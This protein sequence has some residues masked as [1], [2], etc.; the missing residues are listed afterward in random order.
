NMR[1]F[2]YG[3]VALFVTLTM[4]IIDAAVVPT[5]NNEKPPL[6]KCT[7]SVPTKPV[8]MTCPGQRICIWHH[9]ECFSNKDCGAGKVCCNFPGCGNTCL[10]L[11]NP[12]A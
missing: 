12:V 5:S 3:L 8:I 2:S 1:S 4:S 10:D 7:P 9:D 6:R 11:K